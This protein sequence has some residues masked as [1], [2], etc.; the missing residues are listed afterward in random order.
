MISATET[1]RR[2]RR[3]APMIA[4]LRGARALRPTAACETSPVAEHPV[5]RTASYEADPEQVGR[6]LLLYSGGLDT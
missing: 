5:E 4:D 1:M 6:V 2:A 3:T